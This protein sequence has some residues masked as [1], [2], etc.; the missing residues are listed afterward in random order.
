VKVQKFRLSAQ[1]V[2]Q[3]IELL[4]AH[5]PPLS[6]RLVTERAIEVANISYL[7]INLVKH[8][9]FPLAVDKFILPHFPQYFK[10]KRLISLLVDVLNKHLGVEELIELHVALPVMFDSAVSQISL[11]TI[12]QI[13]IAAFLKSES[14]TS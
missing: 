1:S 7:Q 13:L 12:F 14:Y 10:R 9:N 6:R 2:G 3:N 8:K 11:P 4:V 5:K